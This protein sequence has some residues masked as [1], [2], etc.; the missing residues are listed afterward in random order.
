MSLNSNERVNWIQ[1]RLEILDAS[2]KDL[3][4]RAAYYHQ[5]L[6]AD[7]QTVHAALQL[8]RAEEL[9][10][11]VELSVHNTRT[12]KKLEEELAAVGVKLPPVQS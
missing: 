3:S 11:T 9:A 7:A 5:S 8:M 10:L 2:R 12:A 6:G 4:R 1:E